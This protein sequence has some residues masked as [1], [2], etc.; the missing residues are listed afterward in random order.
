MADKRDEMAKEIETLQA[1]AR[2]HEESLAKAEA[3]RVEAE[4]IAQ[5]ERANRLAAEASARA[6]AADAAA[7]RRDGATT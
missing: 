1:E 7:A 4:A 6:S 2:A 3:G 5:R